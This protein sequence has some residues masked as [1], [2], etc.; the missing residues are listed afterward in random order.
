MQ[1]EGALDDPF[2]YTASRDVAQ[3]A[4]PMPNR[5]PQSLVEELSN[6]M[7]AGG[8]PIYNKNRIHFDDIKV[9]GTDGEL[10]TFSF[11]NILNAGGLTDKRVIILGFKP[12]DDMAVIGAPDESGIIVEKRLVP[13]RELV[14]YKIV[15]NL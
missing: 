5:V 4:T 6:T 15:G 9:D 7:L 10:I 2:E 11:G 13:Y 14:L 3:E 8:T 1:E 12:A